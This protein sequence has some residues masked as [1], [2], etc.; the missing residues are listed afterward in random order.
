LKLENVEALLWVCC[1]ASWTVIV[2]SG[3]NEEGTWVVC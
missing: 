3:S 2:Q 1:K